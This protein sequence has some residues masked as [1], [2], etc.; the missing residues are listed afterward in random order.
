V[1]RL[2]GVLDALAFAVLAVVAAPWC[3]VAPASWERLLDRLGR[4]ALFARRDPP[5]L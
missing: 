3:L 1:R 2:R 5:P 4:H